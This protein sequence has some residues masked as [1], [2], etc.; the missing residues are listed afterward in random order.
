MPA[1]DPQALAQ[2]HEK[3]LFTR[4]Y[5]RNEAEVHRADAAL[6]KLE[7]RVAALRRSGHDL[8]SLEEPEISGIAGTGITAVFSYGVA[9]HLVRSHAGAVEIAWD[10]CDSLD[11]FGRLLPELLP[12][13]DEDAAVEAHVPYEDW[14][15]AAAKKQSQ[16]GWLLRALEKRFS[17]VCE[18][19]V[20]Y[21]S[22]Q[23]ALRWEFGGSTATRTLMRL[24]RR[25]IFCHN[26]PL[27]GRKDVSLDEIPSLPPLP[28]RKVSRKCGALVLALARDTSA[29]RYR[30]LHGFSWGDPR[31]VQN[32]DA[33]R[34]VE[35]FYSTVLPEHRLPLRGYHA[36]SIWKNGVPIGYFEGLS[37]HERMDAGF[38]LYYTFRAGETAWLYAR[39]LQAM[40][41]LAGASCFVVDPY[42]I[43]HENDEAIDSGAFW[44]YRKLGFRSVDSG[45]GEL[46]AR[47]EQ[48]IAKDPAYRT[49]PATLRRLVREPMIYGFPGAP[50]S[51]WDG[52]RLRR[53]LLRLSG[54]NNG[55]PLDRA[56][57]L[58]LGHG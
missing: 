53:L 25:A 44:F 47:E 14:V 31:R 48:R 18:R 58:R 19:A 22:L 40:H 32:I 37:L 43:G 23:L 11:P 34:G 56:T 16:I 26:G 30:E 4:A 33:G 57:V 36:L 12:L 17:D 52:F 20:R 35:F 41:Q 10:A 21:E 5:P 46:T 51:D 13:C 42:Q 29:V 6:L 45:I 2:L 55:K 24:P 27:L 54:R 28:T 39:I 3:L 50:S 38:N 7:R 8:A 1:A 9:R 49:S 15:R